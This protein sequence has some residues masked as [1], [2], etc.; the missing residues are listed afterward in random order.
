MKR[1]NQRKFGRVLKVRTAL[2]K[3]LATALIEHGRIKTTEAKA[4][5]LSR[6]VDRLIT[7][8]KRESLNSRRQLLG[9]VGEKTAKKLVGEISKANAE[10]KGGYTRII[11]LGQRRSDGAQMAIVEL[12]ETLSVP[13]VA[14]K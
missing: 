3:S 13:A 8:A 9:H 11:R 5:S 10:R 2:Y 14:A 1:G 4:K 12:T 6:A 7:L